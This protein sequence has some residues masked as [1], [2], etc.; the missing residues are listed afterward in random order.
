MSVYV[1]ATNPTIGSQPYPTAVGW[2]TTRR[3]SLIVYDSHG[4]TLA[5]WAP[6]YWQSAV[7][8]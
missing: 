2:R 7:R 1:I 3:G 8:S 5:E 4:M 6:G